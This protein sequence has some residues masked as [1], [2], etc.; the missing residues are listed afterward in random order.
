[1]NRTGAAA[2]RGKKE[3]VYL[4]SGMRE[5]AQSRP[6]LLLDS[7]RRGLAVARTSAKQIEV[8]WPKTRGEHSIN[9]ARDEPAFF[10]LVAPEM[11]TLSSYRHACIFDGPDPCD[12]AAT[13]WLI[14]L[15]FFNAVGWDET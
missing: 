14:G 9:S 13:G 1:L 10:Y 2:E 4:V 11:E 3:L 6:E 5:S 12:S 7:K 15:T 8:M